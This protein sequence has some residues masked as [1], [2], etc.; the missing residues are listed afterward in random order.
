MDD[1]RKE[2]Y[3]TCDTIEDIVGGVLVQN[4]RRWRCPA[5]SI[6]P[7]RAGPGAC[8]WAFGCATASVSGAV[9]GHDPTLRLPRSTAA[10]R[11][12][13]LAVTGS[14]GLIDEYA[15]VA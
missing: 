7:H 4:R 2:S 11:L 12:E 6:W 14:V 5:M 13:G 15:Q 9:G 1:V 10:A 3:F 8:G